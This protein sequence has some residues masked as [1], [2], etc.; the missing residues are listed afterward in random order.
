MY[1][2]QASGV[3]ADPMVGKGDRINTGRPDHR[4]H[5]TRDQHRHIVVSEG[6]CLYILSSLGLV[7]R[8]TK[9]GWIRLPKGCPTPPPVE[10]LGPQ[11]IECTSNTSQRPGRKAKH[12]FRI[13]PLDL[14]AAR[15][16]LAS[17]DPSTLPLLDVESIT[18]H[19]NVLDG[20]CELNALFSPGQV[21]VTD[22]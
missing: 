22:R 13:A 10:K 20:F 16:P 18:A 9:M 21:A 17:S 19:N 3:C 12:L 2:G 4:S 6:S 14:E 1:F 7:C 15:S 11:H 5:R 8:S